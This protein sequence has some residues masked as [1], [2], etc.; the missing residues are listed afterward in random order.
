MVG[1]DTRVQLVQEP[2]AVFRPL[3]RANLAIGAAV[4]VRVARLTGGGA[5]SRAGGRRRS[6]QARR[7]RDG[8]AAQGSGDRLG[9]AL[10]M[11]DT[12]SA[13]SEGATMALELAQ[14]DGREGRR[15]MY[16]GRLLVHFVNG[17]RGVNHRGLDD[18]LLDYWLNGLVDVMMDMLADNSGCRCLRADGP[19]LNMLVMELSTLL[20][21]TAADCGLVAFVQDPL[22]R[23]GND[24]CVFLGEDDFVLD[25]L[26]GG[27]VMVLMN[28]AVDDGLDLLMF[29]L[30]DRF[31]DHG[32][33][34]L[35]VNG[36]V[37]MTG[38]VEDFADG[39]LGSLHFG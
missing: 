14:A 25:R 12:L 39:M 30:L 23:V 33:G 3:L 5:G 7:S 22:L 34:D 29:G 15:G 28:L 19:G 31:L 26:N 37:V 10:E 21:E 36:G 6:G 13:A 11:I 8:G 9:I 38:P 4:D 32:G 18:L 20:L 35:L 1:V 2:A 16:S 24:S 17:D 27:M